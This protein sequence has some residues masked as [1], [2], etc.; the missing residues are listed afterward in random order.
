LRARTDGRRFLVA[1]LTEEVPPS[2]LTVI[3]NWNHGQE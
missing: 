3:V 1:R 2:P